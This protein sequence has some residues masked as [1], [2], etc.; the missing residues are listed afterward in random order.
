[1]IINSTKCVPREA[2]K[3]AIETFR[4]A[5]KVPAPRVKEA[6]RNWIIYFWEDFAG[7]KCFLKVILTKRSY[8]CGISNQMDKVPGMPLLPF[9]DKYE[10][11]ENI[12]AL[13]KHW[14]DLM[15]KYDGR[16]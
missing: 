2:T 16:I 9:T 14:L 6:R 4:K 10:L 15:V 12:I 3:S 11:K 8:A 5:F 7:D 13:L 1:M